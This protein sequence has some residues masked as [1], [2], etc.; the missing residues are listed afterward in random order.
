MRF[1]PLHLEPC[2]GKPPRRERE[3][4]TGSVFPGTAAQAEAPEHTGLQQGSSV[5]E[6]E[7]ARAREGTLLWPVLP[8]CCTAALLVTPLE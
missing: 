7:S 8:K 2:K 3:Q 6:G 5:H 4:V 1:I